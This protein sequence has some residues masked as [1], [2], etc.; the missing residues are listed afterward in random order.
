MD[1]NFDVRY[2][3]PNNLKTMAV[4][5]EW[6]GGDAKKYCDDSRKFPRKGIAIFPFRML[7]DKEA[8]LASSEPNSLKKNVLIN[9]SEHDTAM[10]RKSRITSL[11]DFCVLISLTFL[12]IQLFSYL[13]YK[14][15]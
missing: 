14:T 1:T 2:D 11:C 4:R 9:R 10:T 5:A 8:I 13:E 6:S 12:K 15:I 3:T 7:K